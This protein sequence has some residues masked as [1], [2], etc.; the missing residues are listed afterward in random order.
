MTVLLKER[1]NG[2]FSG[3]FLLTLAM[4]PSFVDICDAFIKSPVQAHSNPA[5]P[6]RLKMDASSIAKAGI[7]EQQQD[8]AHEVAEGVGRTQKPYRK[9]HWH[10]VASWFRSLSPAEHDYAIGNQE[11]LGIVISCCYWYRY[12]Q[13]PRLLVE[14][15]TYSRNLQRFMTTNSP[16][17][18]QARWWET[19]SSYD[20]Y[21]G[22]RAGKKNPADA[23][24][25]R[26]N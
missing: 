7:I 12:L 26:H 25:C 17:G 24:C 5:R 23:L 8:N 6:I 14:V 4:K 18:R 15:L 2:H 10:P 21:I 11:L 20:L 22:Y 13:D 3:P 9:G 16:M 19:L 1:N